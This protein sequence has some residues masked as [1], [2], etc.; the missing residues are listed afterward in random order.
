MFYVYVLQS[1][2]NK[3]IYVGYST[4]L[5]RRFFEH[6]RRKVPSTQSARPW[7]LVFYEAYLDKN[8]ATKREKQLKM[9]AAK[10]ALIG[11]IKNS[12]ASIDGKIS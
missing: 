3:D 10:N 12:L 7:K 11:Q 8:D 9:H 6:S 1:H 2:H 4:D 5:K